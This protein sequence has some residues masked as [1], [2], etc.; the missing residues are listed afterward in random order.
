M[1]LIVVADPHIGIESNES[2]SVDMA[3]HLV[4]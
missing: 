3:V 1:K 4:S 2:Q